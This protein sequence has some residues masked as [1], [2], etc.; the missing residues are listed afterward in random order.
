MEALKTGQPLSFSWGDMSILVKPHA[1]S[2]D[3]LQVA[4]EKP[5]LGRRFVLASRL[6]VI[7]WKGLTR[8]GKEVPYSPEE[9]DSIPDLPGK[10]F[11]DQLGAFVWKNTDISGREDSDLKN[12]LRQPSNGDSGPEPSTAAAK[13]A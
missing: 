7:G 8:E 6:M 1:T 11:L 5:G 9:L 2:D 12:D 3:R 4:L 13:T 10:N